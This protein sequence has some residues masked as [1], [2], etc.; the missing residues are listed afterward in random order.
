MVD[1]DLGEFSSSHKVVGSTIHRMTRALTSGFIGLSLRL[2]KK[3][4]IPTSRA[5]RVTVQTGMLLLKFTHQQGPLHRPR[6][7]NFMRQRFLRTAEAQQQMLE[8][9]VHQKMERMNT[10]LW[11]MGKEGMEMGTS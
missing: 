3:F 9:D 11:D 10:E 4:E 5:S 7:S 8:T 6:S 1:A 2:S